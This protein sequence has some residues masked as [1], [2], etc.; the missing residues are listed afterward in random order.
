MFPAPMF[1]EKRAW[2]C[3]KHFPIDCHIINCFQI[4]IQLCENGFI[5]SMKL[6]FVYAELVIHSL[7][8]NA[9]LYINNI[10][11]SHW[12]KFKSKT[13]SD[14]KLIITS[15]QCKENKY[16][17]I[18]CDK[19]MPAKKRFSLATQIR[20]RLLQISLILQTCFLN[21]FASRSYFYCSCYKKYFLK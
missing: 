19:Y 17:V 7:S 4:L 13:S 10:N 20:A 11:W 21:L 14:I 16:F 12:R 8:K 1:E 6:T 9:E 18:F 5:C 15:F 2:K 3:K